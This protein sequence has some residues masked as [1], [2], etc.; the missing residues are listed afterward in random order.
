TNHPESPP[1]PCR[2]SV[3]KNTKQRQHHDSEQQHSRVED[4]CLML[5]FNQRAPQPLDYAQR[6]YL[7]QMLSPSAIE[8]EIRLHDNMFGVVHASNLLPHW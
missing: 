6:H 8:E 2:F 1:M 5:L 3:T 7:M 4:G